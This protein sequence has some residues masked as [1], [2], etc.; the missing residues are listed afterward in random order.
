MH[1]CV[2]V[3]ACLDA[4][5]PPFT[6]HHPTY[7]QPLTRSARLTMASSRLGAYKSKGILQ[8]DDLRRRRDDQQVEIR[9]QKREEGNA[10]RRQM[11]LT[12]TDLTDEE[13]EDE[14]GGAS[15]LE[16]RLPPHHPPSLPTN[17]GCRS[18]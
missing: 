10:K 9:R 13:D 11:D 5:S 3:R 12:A 15:C 6:N 16:V 2:C 8:A 14:Y 1:A 18:L 17:P 4:P 7:R